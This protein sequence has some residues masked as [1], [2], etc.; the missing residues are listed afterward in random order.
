MFRT[1]PWAS[2]IQVDVELITIVELEN[3]LHEVRQRVVAIC[4]IMST[5]KGTHHEPH[6]LDVIRN[7]SDIQFILDRRRRGA[8]N[9][10]REPRL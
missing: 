2:R 1:V 4:I 7:V 5:G 10:L 6:I 9:M 8:E 3:G